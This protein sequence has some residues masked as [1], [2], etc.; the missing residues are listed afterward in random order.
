MSAH[1]LTQKAV[2][3]TQLLQTNQESYEL[4]NIKAGNDK[5]YSRIDINSLSMRWKKHCSLSISQKIN[6]YMF[7]HNILIVTSV[8]WGV[9]EL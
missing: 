4:Y 6:V 7:V 2:G 3:F 1:W 9:Y 5:I 8:Q